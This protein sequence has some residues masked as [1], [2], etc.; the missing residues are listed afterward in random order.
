MFDPANGRCQVVDPGPFTVHDLF[1]FQFA[2]LMCRRT[3]TVSAGALMGKRC[4]EERRAQCLSALM[5]TQVLHGLA[6][7]PHPCV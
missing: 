2:L 5:W 3:Q 4:K 6:G 7:Q 1:S